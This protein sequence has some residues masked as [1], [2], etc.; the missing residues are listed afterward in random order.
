MTGFVQLL[1]N[2]TLCLYCVTKA[3][4]PL[5]KQF[6]SICHC[7]FF[8]SVHYALKALFPQ[9]KLENPPAKLSLYLQASWRI[10]TAASCCYWIWLS[11]M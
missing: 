9:G 4:C 10:F 7:L 2:N 5:K 8:A 3:I 1:I 6:K 11:R